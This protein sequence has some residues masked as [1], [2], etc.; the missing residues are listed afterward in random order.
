[1]NVAGPNES[2]RRFYEAHGYGLANVAYRKPLGD[3][4]NMPEV[5][6]ED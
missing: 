2:A 5:A 3:G 6:Q 1:M 4:E